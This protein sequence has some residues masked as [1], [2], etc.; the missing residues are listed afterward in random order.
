VLAVEAETAF[1]GLL[2]ATRRS[3][4]VQ[5]FFREMFGSGSLE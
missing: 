1:P 4:T 3:N 2:V 5:S